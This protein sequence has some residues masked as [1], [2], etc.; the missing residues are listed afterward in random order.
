[1]LRCGQLSSPE[2]F[3]ETFLDAVVRDRPDIEPAELE[4]QQHLHR[5]STDPAHAREPLDNFFV[6]HPQ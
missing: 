2:G 6:R 4:Q 1:L 3:R 5:P